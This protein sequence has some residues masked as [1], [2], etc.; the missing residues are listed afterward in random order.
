MG[1]YS[2]VGLVHCNNFR[3]YDGGQNELDNGVSATLCLGR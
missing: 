1:V 3:A 2:K